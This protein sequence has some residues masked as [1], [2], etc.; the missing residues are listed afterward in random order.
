MTRR[1]G[2]L[3]F[4]IPY[5]P[6]A[7]RWCLTYVGSSSLITYKIT[8]LS[9]CSDLFP[10]ASNTIKS[11]SLLPVFI[12]SLAFHSYFNPLSNIMK[13]FVAVALALTAGTN[14]LV[15]RANTCCFGLTASGA[16]VGQLPDGQ[17]RVVGQLPDGQNR[18]VGQILDGQNRVGGN[19]PAGSFCI[20]S[21][22]GAITD[23][24]G[25]GCILTS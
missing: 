20:D 11:S 9:L 6:K 16:N 23:G 12:H 2:R 25:R 24:A 8:P 10:I 22:N 14:A 3:R 18:I 4:L 13:T 1:G 7:D 19:L 15:S 5:L 21:S 17:N